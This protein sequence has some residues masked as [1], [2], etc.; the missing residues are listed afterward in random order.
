M[1]EARTTYDPGRTRVLVVAAAAGTDPATGRA[2]GLAEALAAGHDVI[3][4][5]PAVT[6]LTHPAFAIVYY[7]R[8][9]LA[10]M[11]RDSDAVVCE[12]AA[13]ADQPFLLE[14][15]RPVA[16]DLAAI[17]PE[18]GLP[19]AAAR[20]DFFFCESDKQRQGWLGFLDA[21]GRVNPRTRAGD[22]RL[23]RLLDAASAAAPA[24]IDA[25]CGQPR[26]AADRGTRHNRLKLPPKRKAPSR[27]RRYLG[28]ARY[29]LRTYGPLSLLSRGGAK[30]GN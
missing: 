30:R 10:L 21:A 13:A 22:E 17:P 8:R 28:A 20:A 9:N 7:N 6:G 14:Q 1:N 27:P 23:T 25:F 2:W 15:G 29:H 24:A 12:A 18:A 19:A 5:L 11:V 3:L 4:A 26:F 16:L